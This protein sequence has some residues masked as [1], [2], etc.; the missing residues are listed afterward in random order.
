MPLPRY[1]SLS[2]QGS[3]WGCCV[4]GWNVLLWSPG[5][6]GYQ[7]VA[8]CEGLSRK[9]L[10]VVLPSVAQ[11]PIYFLLG[12]TLSFSVIFGFG[13]IVNM[14]VAYCIS[15]E[16]NA[17]DAW[18]VTLTRPCTGQACVQLI[19]ADR[20]ARRFGVVHGSSGGLFDRVA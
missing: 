13:E 7:H 2:S 6:L 12:T 8:I 14:C 20:A 19:E 4:C 15:D 5:R 9:V 16:V 18:I 3:F 10:R 11:V 17:S 1:H